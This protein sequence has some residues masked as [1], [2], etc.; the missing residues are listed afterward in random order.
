[1]AKVSILLST[2]NGSRYLSEQLLSIKNQSYQE[3]ELI[4]R[5]D[6]SNDNTRSIIKKFSDKCCGCKVI[7]DTKG[8]VGLTKS[9]KILLEHVDTEYSMF[10]D[11]D[12]VWNQDKIAILLNQIQK[13]SE[14]QPS[15]K[16]LMV[17]ADSMIVDRDL[18]PKRRFHGSAPKLLGLRNSLFRF[19]VQGA[20]TIF[21]KALRNAIVKEISDAYIHDRLAHLLV[22]FHGVR[23]YVDCPLMLYRQHE[24]NL[25]G[26][27][28]R[29]KSRSI[30][31]MVFQQ[32]FFQE[33]DRQLILKLSRT[34]AQ[35]NLIGVYKTLTS[36]EITRM[37]KIL[38]VRKHRISLRPIDFARLCFSN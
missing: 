28:P 13:L 33:I 6:G 36:P 15:D 22:E 26:A 35:E 10:C 29:Y 3:W 38:L 11:Q 32:K 18:N 37:T 14:K 5:D 27:G 23:N 30:L 17:H 12:D 31:K 4:V 24:N 9:L 20:S 34:G 7:E 21:N 1:M 19:H 2:Y 25:L 8:N 16:M